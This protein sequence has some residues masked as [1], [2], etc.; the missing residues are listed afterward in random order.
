MNCIKTAYGK[1]PVKEVEIEKIAEYPRI[2]LP[3][4]LS[5]FRNNAI[6]KKSQPILVK[7]KNK[8]CESELQE[9]QKTKNSEYILL[10]AEYF[11]VRCSPHRITLPRYLNPKLAYLIGYLYGD[12]GLKDIRRSYKTTGVFEHKL[13]VG[14]EFQLQIER[15]KSLFKELFNLHTTLRTERID[16]GENMY[17]LN[18]TCKLIYR[19]LVKVFDFPEGPKRNLAVP[20]LIRKAPKRIRQWFLRGFIDADGDTRATEY[21]LT[22]ALPSPRI[23]IKLA[24]KRLVLYLKNMLNEDFNLG[25]T[26]PYSDTK[27]DYYIQTAKAGTIRAN[28]RNLFKHP[29]KKWR[30]EKFVSLMGR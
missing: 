6:D 16:K 27:K 24:D 21:Y 10:T 18:P 29:I 13:I 26:G 19:F 5:T 1:I 22:S 4:Y 14:D 12:G 23:K 8:S 20:K 17:Y 30:L 3:N 2:S 25:F 7:L 9:L 28:K 15:I 11:R